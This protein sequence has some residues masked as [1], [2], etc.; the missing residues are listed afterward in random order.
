MIEIRDSVAK[1]L[2]NR[3]LVA[4][5]LWNRVERSYVEI[6]GNLLIRFNERLA[7]PRA[8]QNSTRVVIGGGAIDIYE[9]SG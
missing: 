5:Y 1:K 6:S 2:G 8:I 7:I 3:E 9:S 4:V